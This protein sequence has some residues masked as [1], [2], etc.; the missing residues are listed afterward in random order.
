M[1]QLRHLTRSHTNQQCQFLAAVVHKIQPFLLS[2]QRCRNAGFAKP[3]EIN[4]LKAL[5]TRVQAIPSPKIMLL[6]HEFDRF[7]R[8]GKSYHQ[9][10]THLHFCRAN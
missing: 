3:A 5:F 9:Y 1:Y 7:L 10:K 4:G 6:S 2:D 8:L